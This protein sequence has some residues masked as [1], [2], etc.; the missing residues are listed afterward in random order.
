MAKID[1]A[2]RKWAEKMANAGTRWKAGVTDKRDA[3]KRG[4]ELF[5]GVTA[6][7]TLADNYKRGVDLVTA[8]DFQSAVR[9]KE[10]KWAS[11]LVEAIKR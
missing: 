7:N 3:Y 10:E 11:R 4:L 9:G 8:E 2:K 6:G 5:A 1:L